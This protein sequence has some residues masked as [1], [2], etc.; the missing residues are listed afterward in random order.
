MPEPLMLA[1]L[2]GLAL[3]I[4]TPAA[5]AAIRDWR[6]TPRRRAELPPVTA[7]LTLA[8]LQHMADLW[9]AAKCDLAG[10]LLLDDD[11]ALTTPAAPTH[12]EGRHHVG[13]RR[14]RTIGPDLIGNTRGAH[15]AAQ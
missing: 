9:Y 4:A 1:I 7:G 3:L 14:S 13:P 12:P 8:D 2:I 6:H 15:R 10:R 11:A 5:I